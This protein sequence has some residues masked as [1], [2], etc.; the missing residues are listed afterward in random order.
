MKPPSLRELTRELRS[1]NDHLDG[2]WT[3]GLGV[4]EDAG[5]LGV[6]GLDEAAFCRVIVGAEHLPGDAQPFDAVAAARRLLAAF[7]ESRHQLEQTA[8]AILR[9]R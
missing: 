9:T 1:L 2:P 8:A 7:R 4:D 3:V 5:T 6:F